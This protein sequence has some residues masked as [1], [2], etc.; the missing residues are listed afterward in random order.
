[1]LTEYIKAAMHRAKYKQY[2]EDNTFFG[3]IPEC[4]GVWASA[5][6]LEVCRDKLESVL[7]GWIILGLRFGDELPIIDGIKLTPSLV[8]IEDKEAVENEEEA[9]A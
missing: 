7:E 5:E 8:P 3:N 2:E 1:M 4:Q 9:I 6:T